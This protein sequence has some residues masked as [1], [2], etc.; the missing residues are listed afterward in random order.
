MYQLCQYQSTRYQSTRLRTK[1]KGINIEVEIVT[2]GL[3]TKYE[4]LIVSSLFFVNGKSIIS[5][6]IQRLK[7]ML[8]ILECNKWGMKINYSKKGVLIVNNKTNITSEPAIKVKNNL[9]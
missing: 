1:Y 2:E 8:T 7:N 9:K 5:P 6:D 3:E 4:C